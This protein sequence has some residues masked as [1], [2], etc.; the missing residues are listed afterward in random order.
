MAV[1]HSCTGAFKSVQRLKKKE[2]QVIQNF[3]SCGRVFEKV[4][5]KL[6]MLF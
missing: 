6:G 1:C 3:Y 5:T 2:W 4:I